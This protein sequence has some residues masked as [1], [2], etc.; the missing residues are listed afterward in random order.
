M[1]DGRRNLLPGLHDSLYLISF[2]MIGFAIPTYLLA[3]GLE[4][5]KINKHFQFVEIV[6]DLLDKGLHLDNI[7]VYDEVLKSET[8]FHCNVCNRCVELFDHHCP[9]I[10]NC[11]G[12]NNHKYFL[13]FLASYV[14]FLV[15]L[16]TEVVRH[17][18]EVFTEINGPKLKDYIWPLILSLLIILNTPVVGF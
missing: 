1:H 16:L 12:S 11:L 15:A 3:V 8:S 13:V 14:V 5:G 9:F 7:C 17:T 18:V 4:P 10:N 2:I 6:D